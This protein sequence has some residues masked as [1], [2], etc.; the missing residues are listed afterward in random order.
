MVRSASEPDAKVASGAAVAAPNRLFAGSS[1]AIGGPVRIRH[2]AV[3]ILSAQPGT[4]VSPQGFPALREVA[5]FPAV[6]GQ[7]PGLLRRKSGTSYRRPRL[8]G[9][10]SAR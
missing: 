2:T 5:I 3:R 10:V 1:P 9:R 4:G 7:E 6:S 8:S